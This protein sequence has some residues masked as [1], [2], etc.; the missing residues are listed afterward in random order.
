M[1]D[2]VTG[3]LRALIRLN[4]VNPPGNETRVAEHLRH[5]LEAAGVECELY[6]RAPERANLVA[7]LR[8]TGDGPSLCLLSHTDT[9]LADP[10]EWQVDPWAGELR[11]GQ[12]WGR[13]ALDCKGQVAAGAVAMAALARSGFRPAGDL[14]LVAAAD[15]EGGTDLG[16]RWLCEA[17][18]NA[19]RCD[20]AINEGGGARLEIDGR[21]FYT[22]GTA[23]KAIVPLTLRVRG[24]SG[25]AAR[26]D[27]ADNALV[28]AAGLIERLAALQADVVLQPETR[29]LLALL[30]GGSAPPET[31]PFLQPVLRPTF[32]PT[33]VAASTKVNVI[34]GTCDVSVDCRLLPGQSSA[35][36]E[37]LLR[38]AL[39]E[40]DYE[41]L[42]SG[43]Q[44]GT[45]SPLETPLW[46]AVT[47]FVA[48]I[49][50]RAHVA[51]IIGSGFT[52]SHWLR[53]TFGTVTY[54]FFPRRTIDPG[55]ASRLAHAADERVP[56]DDLELG[57][58]FL[59]HIAETIGAP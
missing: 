49:E 50:P 58:C 16:V 29:A 4:T 38:A 53:S 8:G 7:R 55:L 57:A 26:P 20:Y 45:R 5:Y 17:H 37:P 6:A 56:V 21:V 48:V 13:G 31:L 43:S 14:V 44:G 39:G 42:W 15:E 2:E 35:D 11:D 9:V 34:P 52:D 10:A 36:V 30:D 54:G 3:L 1:R 19:I 18:P 40:G 23:E 32:S 33:M 47:G 25:H 27:G 22:C 12:V 46:D 41:L 28:K 59:R 51:P 24:R